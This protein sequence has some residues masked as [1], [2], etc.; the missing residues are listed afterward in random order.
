MLCWPAGGRKTSKN[1]R[2]S[3]VRPCRDDESEIPQLDAILAEFELPE[4]GDWIDLRKQPDK[5]EE[6]MKSPVDFT[7]PEDTPRAEQQN[8]FGQPKNPI[9]LTKDTVTNNAPIPHTITD[10]PTHSPPTEL[11]TN[12][13]LPTQPSATAAKRQATAYT[14]TIIHP[15]H[16]MPKP[17]SLPPRPL[18]PKASKI[19]S[20]YSGTTSARRIGKAG[21]MSSRSW[22]RWRARTK[23]TCCRDTKPCS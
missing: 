14:T 7:P 3:K 6:E 4:G 13:P 5:D 19:P 21:K 10:T 11:P 20:N 2:F 9:D 16:N 8:L 17:K 12:I 22:R 1:T 15:P 18:H 23:T